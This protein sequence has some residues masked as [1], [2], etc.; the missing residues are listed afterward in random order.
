M[1]TE[2]PDGS[3]DIGDFAPRTERTVA[4][5]RVSSSSTSSHASHF[6]GI[7]SLAGRHSSSGGLNAIS[8]RLSEAKR[9]AGEAASLTQHVSAAVAA[10]VAS[11]ALSAHQ[12]ATASAKSAPASTGTLQSS[13]SMVTESI[14][15]TAAEAIARVGDLPLA[16]VGGSS[17]ASV[18]SDASSQIAL[19]I[20]GALFELVAGCAPSYDAFERKQ[21]LGFLFDGIIGARHLPDIASKLLDF[22]YMLRVDAL[23]DW[24]QSQQQ[25]WLLVAC[26]VHRGDFQK[27][28]GLLARAVCRLMLEL[29]ANT[30]QTAPWWDMPQCEVWCR[31]VRNLARLAEE[32]P[33]MPGWT[34]PGLAIARHTTQVTEVTETGLATPVFSIALRDEQGIVRMRG[35]EVAS[36][37]ASDNAMVIAPR[38]QVAMDKSSHQAPHELA[39]NPRTLVASTAVLEKCQVEANQLFTRKTKPVCLQNQASTPLKVCLFNESDV[40]MA[41]PIG[42]IG[43]PCVITLKPSLRAQLRP[44]GSAGRFKMKV[45]APG[46]VDTPLY[47]ANVARGQS[48]Q[49]RSHDCTSD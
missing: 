26:A 32:S 47:Y 13:A 39:N 36:A 45:M 10:S 48:V 31:S 33:P 19:G 14:R 11:A 12:A 42:G 22:W 20:A 29:G 41:V 46:F 7:P 1:A 30:R 43:G 2:T 27:V 16:L 21:E 34:F 23:A 8:N 25:Q 9:L 44:P 3:E 15:S 24:S 5:E 17:M 37:I 6:Q 38:L 28:P 4:E 18:V 35:S 40:L 49:L